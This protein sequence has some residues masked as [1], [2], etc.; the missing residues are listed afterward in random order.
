[1]TEENIFEVEQPVPKDK[2]DELANLVQELKDHEVRIEAMELQLKEEKRKAER[3]SREQIPALF[4]GLGLSMLKLQSGQ[5]V[6]VEDKLKAS[7]ANKNYLLAYRNMIDAD[8]G[9]ESAVNKVDSLFK[10]R[11]ILEE[12]S[13]E[14]MELLLSNDIPYDTKREIHWQTLAKYCRDRLD[15]GEIIPEGIT[16]FQYQET[17]IK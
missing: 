6:S 7:I 16:V 10:S 3:I 14:V 1:M 5:V 11:I 9:D 12:V 13:D 4:N 15:N 17:K 2:M 8:G